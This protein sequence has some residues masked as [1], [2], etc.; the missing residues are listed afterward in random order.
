MTPFKLT[1]C[2]ADDITLKVTV[3]RD[4]SAVNLTGA[5]FILTARKWKNSAVLIEV[6]TA[7]ITTPSTGIALI[8]IPAEDTAGFTDDISLHTDVQMTEAD[9]TITTVA[10]GI[11]EVLL[12]ISR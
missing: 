6:T 9:G 12:D 2:R 11:L 7:T 3:T 8:T 10:Y 1:A 4:G 5:S